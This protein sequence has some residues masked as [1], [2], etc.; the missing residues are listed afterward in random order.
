[1]FEQRYHIEGNYEPKAGLSDIFSQMNDILNHYAPQKEITYETI[2]I[3]PMV[4]V[5]Q[6]AKELLE[7]LKNGV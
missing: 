7:L 3:H 1:M 2:G 6:A 4:S 5:D